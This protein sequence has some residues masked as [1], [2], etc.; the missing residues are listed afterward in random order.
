MNHIEI[1]ITSVRASGPLTKLEI[2]SEILTHAA[3]AT[4][5]N[6][7]HLAE[8]A[9]QHGKETGWIENYDDESFC[10]A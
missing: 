6:C 4:R 5:Q 9:I 1:A 10:M 2:A 8:L 3:N 7:E